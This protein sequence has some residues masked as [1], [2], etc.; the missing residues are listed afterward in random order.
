M[1]TE[2]PFFGLVTC[3]RTNVSLR[4]SST[5]WTKT[6]VQ[7][8]PLTTVVVLVTLDLH[9]STK[10]LYVL[11]FRFLDFCPISIKRLQFKN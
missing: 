4:E 8:F 5:S 3:T 2:E 7:T 10:G 6:P 1:S 11:L 9:C